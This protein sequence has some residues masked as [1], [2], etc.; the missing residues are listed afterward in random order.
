MRCC[1]FLSR[2]ETGSRTGEWSWRGRC[3]M[4]WLMPA[5]PALPL[6]SC[7]TLSCGPTGRGPTPG[8]IPLHQWQHQKCSLL[9]LTSIH[10]ACS[11]APL[12]PVSPA[13]P[14]TLTTSTA[15]C[16]RESCSPPPRL[17]WRAP[18]QLTL[19]TTDTVLRTLH[20]EAWQLL[21]DDIFI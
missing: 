13:C 10:T 9:L 16:L 14:W 3:R 4:P 11:T 20:K 2:S 17:R 19:S 18:T 5:R 7:T 15:A 1:P 21:Y 8:I 12:C 6:S